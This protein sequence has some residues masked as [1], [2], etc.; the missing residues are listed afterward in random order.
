ML[1]AQYLVL[2]LRLVRSYLSSCA[3]SRPIARLLLL[4]SSLR[5]RLFRRKPTPRHSLTTVSEDLHL[6]R[7]ANSALPGA[8]HA[9]RGIVVC[10]SLVPPDQGRPHG[11]D[12]PSPSD[13]P[14]HDIGSSTHLTPHSPR[15]MRKLTHIDIPAATGSQTSLASNHLDAEGT[16]SIHRPSSAASNDTRTTT[17][18]A[19]LNATPEE[20][21]LR[22]RP[23]S[24]VLANVLP[25]QDAEGY[26]PTG[27][28]LRPST[29]RTSSRR[30]LAVPTP[31]VRFDN[32]LSRP[33]SPASFN[34]RTSLNSRASGRSTYRRHDGPS[35][36]PL[37]NLR[38]ASTP[39]LGH[40]SHIGSSTLRASPAHLVAPPS[41]DHP[42][43]PGDPVIVTIGPRMWPMSTI[44]V[45]RYD[46]S[47][48]PGGVIDPQTSDHSI[49]ALTIEYPSH[50]GSIPDGWSAH[51]HPE[52]ARYFL[53]EETRTFTELDICDPEIFE[54]IDYYTHYL[55]EALRQTIRDE[56][57]PLAYEEI[58][59]VLEPK[60]DEYGVLCCYY[61]VN[62]RGRCLF[63][64]Q[65]YDACLILQDCKGVTSLSHKK[66]AVQ[67]QYWKHWDLFPN[68][69]QVTQAIVDE[70]RDM[71][72][73]A[74]C[75][76][77]T[78]NRSPAPFSADE[79]KTQL[80]IVDGIKV[81]SMGDKHH[82]AIIVAR[83]KYMNFH[84]Q[85]GARLC[86]DQTVH[87]WSYKRSKIMRTV[88]PLLFNAPNAHIRA[89]HAI[90]V[91]QITS[92]STW[93]KFTT[94]LNSELQDFNLMATVLLNA[95]VG[96]LAIQTVDNGGG[97]A[98]TQ[99]ASYMSLVA[100]F[101]SIVLGLT[102]VRHNRTSGRDTAHE[103]AKFLQKMNHEKHGL[104]KL[105]IAY[106]LPYALLMW[107]MVFFLIA[108]SIE[109]CKPG[110]IPSRVP[111]GLV[112][113]AVCALIIWCAY[114]AGDE[115]ER[116]RETAIASSPELTAEPEE[117]R[118]S[119]V[120]PSPSLLSRLRGSLKSRRSSDSPI[121]LGQ[122]N[123]P[124][125]QLRRATG[126]VGAMSIAER[127]STG[128]AEI[129]NH[130]T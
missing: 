114:I 29:S 108:F 10:P 111:V 94:K 93:N 11:A 123:T 81:D 97:R 62:P 38:P 20:Q 64:L 88:A 124:A 35:P 74:S 17:G 34:S 18:V 5:Q 8:G 37:S 130:P 120:Q 32:D 126:D 91:D 24:P 68:M 89:L 101:G 52:G 119:P 92:I 87:G 127:N 27:S 100:S 96:F 122:T 41:N 110:D 26:W 3:S 112:L 103:A 104:E 109:W 51:V 106:S 44:G 125:I 78:S 15:P 30:N 40:E 115:R 69:C 102:F 33:Q 48:V 79:L 77:L 14:Y 42:D 76:H 59:L 31:S 16:A 117:Y 23:R 66:F 19:W 55:H 4:L 39:T 107:G 2:V 60:C 61:F 85:Q 58:E 116:P 54:D 65:D 13:V 57:L 98:L 113:F 105:A 56:N 21:G 45:N 128:S 71:M 118:S 84:G 121:E 46:R 53:H 99:I 25:A 50:E 83:N 47:A 67:A 6:G 73:H 9:L 43:Q 86:F 1:A 12:P 129:L 72:L 36:R 7:M 90:F 49:T 63:W 28:P 70:L 75:D 82:S 80:P 95:N 22:Q